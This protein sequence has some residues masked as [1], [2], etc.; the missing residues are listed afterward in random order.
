[1]RKEAE[2]ERAEWSDAV[3]AHDWER[4]YDLLT[5]ADRDGSLSGHELEQLAETARW[6]R[7]YEEM[8]ASLER[9]CEAFER[10]G[11]RI[12][13]GRVAVKLVI[14]YFQRDEMALA[15]G[16]LGRATE[17]LG[18][19]GDSRAAGMILFCRVDLLLQEGDADAAETVA[20]EMAEMA[21]RLDD[22]DLEALAMMAR[23]RARQL[24]GGFKEGAALLDQAA[25][26]ALAGDLE[27]WTSGFVICANINAC[28]HRYDIQTAS[29][30]SEAAVRWCKRQ[31][32]GYF[33]GL[34]RL[35]RGESLTLRGDYEAAT[36][37]VEAAT[38]DLR[39]GMP[40]YATNGVHELG[41]IKRRQGDLES[42][43]A[44]FD[45]AIE[46]GGDAMPGLVLLRLDQDRPGAALALARDRLDGPGDTRLSAGRAQ[47]LPA[48]IRAAIEAADL[49]YAREALTELAEL[50]TAC[51]TAALRAEH[52]TAAG[53][54][55]LADGDAASSVPRF[56]EARRLWGKTASPYEGAVARIELARA[57][58]ELGQREA[59]END[60]EA[61]LAVFERIG[62]RFEAARA[63]RSIAAFRRGSSRA[64]VTMLFTDIVGST[65]LVE[66]LGDGPWESL[67]A[68]HDRALRG[69]LE[70]SGGM[71]I[72]HEGDGL[73]A[74]FDGPDAALGCACE[75]QRRLH[76]HQAE[77]GYAPSVRIGVH[78]DEVNDRG[79]DLTGR[80]V[81]IAARVMD[82]A[83][84]GEVL[85]T[86]TTLRAASREYT[87]DNE[88]PL[89]AKGVA[90]PLEVVSVDWREGGG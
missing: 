78:A 9:A 17:L 87:L 51:D 34:C 7:R 1:V 2:P 33:P 60:A 16:S 76:R 40:R 83:A 50:A 32:I 3:V 14:E 21:K 42:A 11:E 12:D 75:I 31:S 10:D 37:E 47:V 46:L 8:V 85:T 36:V 19:E 23:G 25:A 6:T 64:R 62:A 13:A 49:D 90:E 80:G 89:D 26:S 54:L 39:V 73:F 86:S 69:C 70:E 66:A 45:E 24:A 55:E 71:E 53:R 52:E 18:E 88:R 67:L 57:Q 22:H 61:A 82:A 38:E 15:G 59:A 84:G 43:A 44:R 27:L 65:K 63:R 68:W 4:A 48:A 56:R 81:H 58:F 30:W 35:H 28:R 74:A 77:H 72:K 41:E 5:D 29:E 79:D 20:I